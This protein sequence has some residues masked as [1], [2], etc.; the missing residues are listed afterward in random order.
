[1]NYSYKIDKKLI[2]SNKLYIDDNFDY[3]ISNSYKW[4]F[5]IILTYMIK[6]YA[7]NNSNGMNM[8]KI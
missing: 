3:M 5:I 2:D 4:V 8:R 7:N 1:M 6:K